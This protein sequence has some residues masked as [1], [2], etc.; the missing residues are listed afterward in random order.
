MRTAAI[1]AVNT[2][3]ITAMMRRNSQS[4][5]H[6]NAGLGLLA[7]ALLLIALAIP[8][9]ITGWLT[10]PVRLDHMRKVALTP[11]REKNFEKAMK[12]LPQAE[13]ANTLAYTAST[14]PTL[15]TLERAHGNQN[16]LS[17][18]RFSPGDPYNWYYLA[19][20]LEPEIFDPA[21]LVLFDHALTMSMMTGPMAR[22]LILSRILL[23]V[24]YWDRLSLPL[25]QDF[26]DQIFNLWMVAPWD[27]REVY[28]AMPP[29][30]QKMVFDVLEQAPGES[31]KFNKY[32]DNPVGLPE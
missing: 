32:L 30:N 5:T 18:V 16:A 29:E 8:Q 12:I 10:A 27:L 26:E 24:K 20:T 13:T 14:K 1:T 23:V 3:S 9:M 17:A 2:A 7:M 28:L 15:T 6:R 31:I 25:H 4:I 11:E 22:T 21:R 19:A